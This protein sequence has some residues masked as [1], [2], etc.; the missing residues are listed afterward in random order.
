MTD[1]TVVES[2]SVTRFANLF[3]VGSVGGICMGISNY[4]NPE[5]TSFIN[6]SQS[7][8]KNIINSV[9]QNDF[10]FQFQHIVFKIVRNDFGMLF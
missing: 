5:R 8:E 9:V 7:N 2:S 6:V 4:W 3:F 1:L 10:F